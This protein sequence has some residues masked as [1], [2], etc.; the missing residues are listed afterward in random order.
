[1][2]FNRVYIALVILIGFSGAVFAQLPSP[3]YG[4]NLG[5]TLEPPC[6]E[7]C[8]CV[9]VTQGMINAVADEGFNTIRIPVAWDSHANSSTYIID[10]AWLA[11]VKEVVDY[12][13][14]ANLYVIINCHWDNG[15]LENNIGNSVD[16]TI[17]AKQYAY[18]TQ[19]ANTF[20]NYD[21]KLLF[22]GCN[23]PNA[24]TVG[25]MATLLVYEQAFVDAVRATGGNNSTR[26]L[27]VQGPNTDI[28]LTYSLMNTLP[29]DTVSNRLMVEVHYY[30]PWQFCGLTEDAGWGDMF[31]FWGQD[32]HSDTLTGRNCTWGEESFLDGQFQKMY[33][34]FVSQGIPVIIGEFGS[35]R[36]TM[37][38]Y[39]DLSEDDE[40]LAS[41]SRTYFD[42][43]ALDSANYYGLSLFYWDNGVYEGGGLFNRSSYAVID[44]DSVRAL[45]GGAA[46]PRPGTDVTPPDKPVGISAELN[47]ASVAIDWSDNTERDLAGYY[48]YR[49]TVSGDDYSLLNST[50]L[51]E[52]QHTD[53][54]GVSEETYYY[55]VIAVDTAGNESDYSVEV[56]VTIPD[57][58]L[59]SILYERWIGISGT[60]VDDLTS[61]SD[62][63]D[64]PFMSEYLTSLQGVTNWSDQYGSRIRGYL[65]PPVTGDYTFW[66]SGDDNCQLWLST[67]G[68]EANAALIAYVSNWTDSEQWN[69]YAEQKSEAITLT[70][71][72]KYYIEV[73]H[74]EG[75][76][77]DNIAAAWAG[78]GISQQVI[79]WA[80]LSPIIIDQSGDLNGDGSVD[81]GDVSKLAELWLLDDC[82]LTSGVDLNG[83]CKVELYEFVQLA[84]NWLE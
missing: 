9:A 36:R 43:Y 10:S 77:G 50:V 29:T 49:S 74:K 6:G 54:T 61:D 63:P 72:Q 21:E 75:S 76:G 30:S 71:G 4:W 41:A 3:T 31:Y 16:S 82:V 52:S 59:G 69:K 39:S 64:A 45:T 58:N 27:V 12:C 42:K 33:N 22:A 84:Q 37:G 34:K 7:G 8:W 44:S 48:V 20:I 55:V 25:E 46:V 67:D 47:G 1:M 2:R 51:A 68:T 18:W 40:E 23:E 81:S 57:T 70:A 11:R 65:Y 24:D 73:L 32:Y 60:S 35:T 83:N 56:A 78:P 17:E 19:I 14:N 38:Y 15:W 26:W 80:Y 13:Y 28:D 66:I 62:Y 53:N 79:D 5:N